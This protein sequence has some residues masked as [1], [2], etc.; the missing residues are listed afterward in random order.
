M[1]NLLGATPRRA[2]RG[3]FIWLILISL[4]VG[5]FLGPVV[6]R[7]PWF[8]RQIFFFLKPSSS[9]KTADTAGSTSQYRAVTMDNDQVFYG[10]LEGDKHDYLVL[11]EAFYYQ[12]GISARGTGADQGNIRIIKVGTELHQPQDRVMLNRD[13]VVTVQT[14]TDE[15]KIIQ[16]MKT[17][18]KE[19]Q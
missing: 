11:T 12:P 5:I 16:A 18:L 17:Y 6:V 19:Q 2:S 1:R 4:L 15:S 10:K 3:R 9:G 14:L 8:P 7:Q 13:H